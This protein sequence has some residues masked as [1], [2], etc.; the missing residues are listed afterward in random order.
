MKMKKRKVVTDFLQLP[1][2]LVCLCLTNLTLVELI[3]ILQTCKILNVTGRIPSVSLHRYVKVDKTLSTTMTTIPSLVKN[4]RLRRLDLPFPNV[5]LDKFS[6]LDV[7]WHTTLRDLTIAPYPKCED[8]S[9]N[10]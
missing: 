10:V 4:M 2:P 6:S 9:K 5:S 8:D 1:V 3:R 7:A